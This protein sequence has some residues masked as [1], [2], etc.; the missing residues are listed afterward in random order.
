[1]PVP[2]QAYLGSGQGL[3]SLGLR[4]HG[5]RCQPGVH[6]RASCLGLEGG[7]LAL[8]VDLLKT[9]HLD[10]RPNLAHQVLRVPPISCHRCVSDQRQNKGTAAFFKVLLFLRTRRRALSFADRC[11]EEPNGVSIRPT[12]LPC[13]GAERV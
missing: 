2:E 5:C 7:P 8:W 10:S 9:C 11:G 3:G 1:M 12:V 6:L 13:V 4:P